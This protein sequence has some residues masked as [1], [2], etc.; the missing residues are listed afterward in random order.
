MT[1]AEYAFAQFM[2]QVK[3]G[4]PAYLRLRTYFS[5]VGLVAAALLMESGTRIDG[6]IPITPLLAAAIIARVWR[7]SDASR[8][9]VAIVAPIALYI[10]W[11]VW[12][13]RS[14]VWFLS[15]S[16][17]LIFLCVRGSKS[18]GRRQGPRVSKNLL[19]V[20]DRLAARL[21]L[22]QNFIEQRSAAQQ[23]G[24]PVASLDTAR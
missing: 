2:R 23:H 19:I 21:R 17:A 16:V 12:S 11:E 22:G 1:P 7:G 20:R 9:A 5:P 3:P 15:Y 6:Y 18:R 10:S 24:R 8:I 13:P 4:R 14:L